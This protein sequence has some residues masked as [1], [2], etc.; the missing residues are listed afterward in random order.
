MAGRASRLSFV[1][2]MAAGIIIG[3]WGIFH[4]S[5]TRAAVGSLGI[6][7]TDTLRIVTMEWVAG[8]LLPIFLGVLLVFL[9][10][11]VGMGNQVA[12]GGTL[13][14]VLALLVMSIWSG[15]TG[16]RTELSVFYKI[17]PFVEALTALLALIAAWIRVGTRD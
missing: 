5:A 8:G 11:Y 9:A 6:Y 16:A 15:F 13:L 3:L 14:A 10:P 17:C 7:D 12:R 2:L 4:V 1:L